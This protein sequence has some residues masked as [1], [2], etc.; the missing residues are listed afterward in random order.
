MTY[1]LEHTRYM[2][3]RQRLD[4]DG[5]VLRKSQVS[6]PILDDQGGYMIFDAQTNLPVHGHNWNLDL[7]EV[8]AWMSD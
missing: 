6:S 1:T 7:D 2:R 5:Y 3:D 8:E 4:R